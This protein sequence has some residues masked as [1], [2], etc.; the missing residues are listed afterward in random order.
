[1][2]TLFMMLVGALTACGGYHLYSQ[3]FRV[4]GLALGQ[5]NPVNPLP[6]AGGAAEL[7]A[8]SDRFE[9]IARLVLPSVVSIEARKPAPAS[10]PGGATRTTEDSGS[11]V[12]IAALDGSG[13]IVITNHHVVAGARPDQVFVNMADGRLLKPTAVLGDP[14]TDIAVIRVEG[15]N[16]PQAKLADSD[17]ARV[18]QWVLALG[19]PFGLNQT[20]T[21]GIISARDRGQVSLGASI[22]IKDF[23]QTDA[24]INPGSSGGPL[25]NLAGEVVGI[26]TAIASQSGSSAGISFSIPSNLIKR[27]VK[28]LL[29]RGSVAHGYLGLQLNPTFEPAEAVSLGL[30][31][32]RG[33]KIDKVVPNSPGDRAGLRPNDV[34]LQVDSVAIRNDNHMINLISMLPVGQKVKLLVWRDR[35]AV[36]LDAE[37]GDWQAAKARLNPV[38]RP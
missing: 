18:G 5:A 22:R 21:H 37:V 36:T 11:G 30:D 38:A 23:I 15:S 7:N 14:E 12:I 25:V 34:V 6:V 17:T 1:M 32:A 2:R 8:L 28:Q 31:R 20:V 26:N 16:L 19:S 35:K 33:A 29:E 24:A 9:Q 3:G 10:T 27:I 13:S 4:G